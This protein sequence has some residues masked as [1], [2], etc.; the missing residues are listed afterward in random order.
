VRLLLPGLPARVRRAH[1]AHAHAG[2]GQ[3][4]AAR[5]RSLSALFQTLSTQVQQ[6]L[7]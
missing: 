1:L 2:R 7:G 5:G 3:P 4:V 6:N